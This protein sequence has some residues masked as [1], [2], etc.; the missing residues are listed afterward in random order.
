[1]FMVLENLSMRIFRKVAMMA[2]S[3]RSVA[4]YIEWSIALPVSL[5]DDRSHSSLSD[6][7]RASGNVEHCPVY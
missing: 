2:V 7:R 6:A 3:F 4:Q 5:V 1:M